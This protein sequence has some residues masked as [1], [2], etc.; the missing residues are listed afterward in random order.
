MNKF[1]FYLIIILLPNSVFAQSSPLCGSNALLEIANIY[2]VKTSIDEINRLSGFD[3]NKGTT[4][5]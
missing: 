4:L 3:P 1:F 5:L 2:G